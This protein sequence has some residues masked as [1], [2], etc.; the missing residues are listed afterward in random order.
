MTQ[1]KNRTIYCR[2]N[3]DVLYGLNSASVD[4]IYLDPPFNKNKTFTAPVGTSAE[5]ASFDDIFTKNKVNEDWAFDIEEDHPPLHTLLDAVKAIEGGASYNY[6]YLI[7][8]A[9]RLIEC[10]RVL[11]DTGSLYLHCDPTMSHYLK[12]AMDY[13]FGEKNFRNEIIWHYRRWTAGNKNFQ[14]MHDIIL[15]YTRSN[16]FTFNLQHEPYGDWIKKDYGYV[17][18]ETG[19]RW[20]WHTVKGNRYKVFLEDENKGVKLND[21]WQIPYLGSTAKERTGYPTQKPLALLERIIKASSNKGDLVLDPFC[22]CATT[23]VAAEKLNRRWVGV[24]VSIEAYEQV[25][26]RIDGIQK[27]LSSD[28][29]ATAIKEIKENFTTTPPTRAYAE[30]EAKAPVYVY[31]FSEAGQDSMYKVGISKNPE[32]RLKQRQGN[33]ANELNKVHDRLCPDRQSARAVESYIKTAFKRKEA[34]N[35][36]DK[37]SK[38]LVRGDLKRIKTAIDGYQ[39]AD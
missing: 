31:L 23:P 26:E 25:K 19:R 33:N 18:E 9:V 22:G 12:L 28:E 8:M 16:E 20:R 6:Y 5:G 32:A 3:L 1:P 7:Y 29:R 24:D 38:E 21:V 17:D 30:G 2:D 11:K 4:L 15:R 37:L 10:H 34:D 39:L 27:E 13:I 36:K 35:P 14:K